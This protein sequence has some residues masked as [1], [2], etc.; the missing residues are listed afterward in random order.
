MYEDTVA[1]LV[2]R[3][4]NCPLL[5]TQFLNGNLKF[6]R[7]HDLRTGL[8]GLDILAG[9]KCSSRTSEKA[10]FVFFFTGFLSLSTNSK[11]CR[12]FDHQSPNP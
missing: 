7:K 11:A 8:V 4:I 10:Q 2:S 3:A 12:S 5:K 1:L 9:G 6:L